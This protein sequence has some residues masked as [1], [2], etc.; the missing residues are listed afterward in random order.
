MTRRRLRISR[1]VSRALSSRTAAL[2]RA[3]IEVVREQPDDLPAVSGDPLL[4]HQALLNIINNAVAAMAGA[5]VALLSPALFAS[6]LREGKLVQPF[7][8]VIAG[9][10]WHYL[11]L[12]PA[13][14][15]P[16]VQGFRAWLEAEVRSPTQSSS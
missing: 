13:A 3:G 8:E 9:P 15:G 4:M 2:K 6:A 14:P 7:P 11:L 5:G 1:V 10:E 16:G 12:N